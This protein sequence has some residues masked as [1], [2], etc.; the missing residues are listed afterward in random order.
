MCACVCVRALCVRVARHIIHG[1]HHVIMNR[2][3]SCVHNEGRVSCS[4]LAGFGSYEI[5]HGMHT[6][7]P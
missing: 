1:P 3:H 6:H 2:M 4:E 5:K 7:F